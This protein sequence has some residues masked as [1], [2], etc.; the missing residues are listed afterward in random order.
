MPHAALLRLAA[1]G[2]SRL[3][4][5]KRP[6]AVCTGPGTAM[7]AT[8]MRLG[9]T[10]QDGL[11]LVTDEGRSLNLVLDPPVVV[12]AQC[13]AAVQRW[14]WRRI[15]AK[16]SLLDVGRPGNGAFIEPIWKLLSSKQQ[17]PEWNSAL[18]GS[19]RSALVGRQWS[20]Q[21]CHAAGFAAHNRCLLCLNG[22]VESATIGG[23][24][25]GACTAAGASRVSGRVAPSM[26]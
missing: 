8:A 22:A 20:Q 6:W 25:S 14:R 13:R 17:D 18:R 24:S 9:W 11:N 16:H 19:L 5:A 4:R 23:P 26:P 1:Q 3:V 2:R 12:V 10:V 7:V 21:R 15:E